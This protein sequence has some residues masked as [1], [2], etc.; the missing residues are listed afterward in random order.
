VSL[1][2]TNVE[3]RYA[4]G[5]SP[6]LHD[7]NL[8]LEPGKVVGIV[9][10]NGA[11]KSTICLCAVGLA[12]GAISGELKGKVT[13][14]D[15]D[16]ATSP[17]HQL[18]QHAGILFQESHTQI[19]SGTPTVWEEVAFGPR[20][21]SLS[22]EEVVER[23]WS[24]IKA[25][26]LE[27]I[28]ERD[29][30][31]LSGG[32]AQLVALA[33]ILALGPRYLILDE[34]TSQLDPL[35]T[36]LVGDTLAATARETGVGILIAEHKTDLLARMCDDVAVVRSGQIIAFGAAADILSDQRLESWGVAAPSDVALK[37]AVEAATL[38]WDDSWT[39]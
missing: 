19:T 9:G 8:T 18:A 20:N 35:G 22:L 25:L 3:Y 32:Q 2:L 30:N 16:T 14:D 10:A 15:L 28:V 5:I 17:T 39:A 37:R 13:I 31:R 36:K 26:G 29:P 33:S 7:V 24:A 34:P 12:P 4:G 11:G 38:P 27:S 1:T 21:L 23:T 6:V